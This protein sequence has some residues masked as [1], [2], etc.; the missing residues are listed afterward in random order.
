MMNT[1]F[2]TAEK[3]KDTFFPS[4][5]KFI[6]FL[7]SFLLLVFI[8]LL[9]PRLTGWALHEILGIVFFIPIIIHLL[10]AWPWI[11]SATKTFMLKARR[12]TTFNFCLNAG[13]FILMIIEII[14]GLAI[15]KVALPF[16][17]TKTIKDEAWESLHVQTLN[18]T[19]L[20]VGL[21]I[22][23]NWDWIV[24][25]FKKRTQN[26]KEKLIKLAPGF[27]SLLWRILLIVAAAAFITLILYFILGFPNANRLSDDNEELIPGI[28]HGIIQFGGETLIIAAVVYIA[29]RWLKLRL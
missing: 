8:L 7:D 16:L 12:R 25:I 27:F 6:I 28:I 23:V 29:R 17:G 26:A 20:F 5:R 2:S 22:A 14:S 3:T 19:K 13:L 15:S 1:D 21:H 4:R 10:I 24:S 11:R 9:S 18:V